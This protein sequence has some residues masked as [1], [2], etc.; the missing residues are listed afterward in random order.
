[1]SHDIKPLEAR[2]FR[3][4]VL[5]YLSPGKRINLYDLL[6]RDHMEKLEVIDAGY[7]RWLQRLLPYLVNRYSLQG[8]RIL[9]LGCGTGEFTVRITLVQ[10]SS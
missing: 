3:E 7:G 9:D 1:M 5:D 10:I 4:A 2:R 8:K 6:V